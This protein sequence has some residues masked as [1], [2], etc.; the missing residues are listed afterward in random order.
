MSAEVTSPHPE[1]PAMR[2]TENSG[3][4]PTVQYSTG[5]TL[6]SWGCGYIAYNAA[7]AA[8]REGLL[9][10]VIAP[11]YNPSDI[12]DELIS[13]V[14]AAAEAT[15]RARIP[16]RLRVRYGLDF[17]LMDN[18]FD[19]GARKLLNVSDIFHGWSHQALFSMKQ[20]RKLGTRLVLERAN[21]HPED[22]VSLVSGEYRKYGFKGRV[23]APL[24][25]WK[26]YR[27]Y[28]LADR[29]V[30]CSEFARESHLRHGIPADKLRVINYGVDTEVFTPG[31][32]QDSTFRVIYCGM[33]CLRKGVQY[34]LQAWKELGL[35][36]SELWL[37]G[38]VLPDAVELM[39]RYE[40]LPGVRVLGHVGSRAELA[41]LYRQGSV[42]AFPS[43]EDGFAMVVTEA[44]ACGIPVIISGNTGAKDVVEDG[45]NGY[46][47]PTCSVEALKE[48]IVQ[49]K[50]DPQLRS[51]LGAS[52]RLAAENNTWYHYSEKL[53]QVYKELI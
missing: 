29:I 48:K 18:A 12:P 24:E 1:A 3:P 15:L 49:L 16:Y 31:P 25:R 30:V 38:M 52:A 50:R 19:L 53:L 32:K 10:G 34:L 22:I 45:V 41:E 33:V 14:A 35:Q 37:V 39:R 51:S 43:V 13:V 6:A 28:A 23:E 40:S 21:T 20:A 7:M 17:C 5:R 2:V 27:E 11:G 36:D 42:F 47:V 26:T 9:T 4:R 8:F 46:V 44:M